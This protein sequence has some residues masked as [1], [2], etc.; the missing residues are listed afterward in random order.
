MILDYS[1]IF[2]DDEDL[3]YG[4]DFEYQPVEVAPETSSEA[5]TETG[6]SS[7]SADASGSDQPTLKRSDSFDDLLEGS[8]VLYPALF[9][10]VLKNG[11]THKNNRKYMRE[12]RGCERSTTIGLWR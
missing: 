2:R 6:S 4:E 10:L 1:S 5:T 7:S 12:T 11:V 8:E 3:L 9:F